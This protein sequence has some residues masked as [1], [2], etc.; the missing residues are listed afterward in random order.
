MPLTNLNGPSI[1]NS[2]RPRPL[3]SDEEVLQN[4]GKFKN[5][6]KPLRKTSVMSQGKD[7]CEDYSQTLAEDLSEAKE[8]TING[9]NEIK[10]IQAV[11]SEDIREMDHEIVI[12]PRESKIPV[13]IK[14]NH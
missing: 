1:E 10:R 2:K 9:S 6:I 12:K 14:Q 4:G 11:Q 7:I 8:D 3:D 13:S 5:S